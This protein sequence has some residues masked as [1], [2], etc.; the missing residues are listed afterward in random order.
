MIS[1]S[2]F[3]PF[4]VVSLTLSSN[5]SVLLVVAIITTRS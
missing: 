1:P 3:T 2:S 4:P 5:F